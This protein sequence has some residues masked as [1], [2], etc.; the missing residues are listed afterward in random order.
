MIP[1]DYDAECEIVFFFNDAQLHVRHGF[2]VLKQIAL[3]VVDSNH[4]L[5]LR[6]AA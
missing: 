4:K 1:S 6:N 3:L 2:L 5:D